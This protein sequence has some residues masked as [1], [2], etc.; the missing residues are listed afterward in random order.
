MHSFVTQ[1]TEIAAAL[2]SVTLKADGSSARV[3]EIKIR[4]RNVVLVV[5]TSSGA[6]REIDPVQIDDDTG[7][8]PTAASDLGAT[9]PRDG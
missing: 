8:P 7:A 5:E 2:P 9:T 6:Y 4:E 3:R 1:L